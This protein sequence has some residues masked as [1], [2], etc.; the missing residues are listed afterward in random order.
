MQ[1][2]FDEN[3]AI[4]ASLTIRQ[5]VALQPGQELIVSAGLHDAPFVRLIV[6]EAYRAGAKNVAILWNDPEVTLAR[7]REATDEAIGYAPSWLYDGI[8]RAYSENAARLAI[9]S[10]DPGLLTGV[11]PERVATSS[12]ANGIATKAM[13]E[14]IGGFLINWCIVGAASPGWAAKV[15]PG[16]PS[17]EAV[18]KLWDAIF[19]TSRIYEADPI[20]AWVA[21]CETLE[22]RMTWLNDLQLD[23]VHFR[24]PG[25]DLRVGLVEGHV[26][27]GGR[28]H[29]R[30][31]VTCSPNIPTEEVF[32][33]PH[34]ARV[35]GYVSSSKP[36]SVRG[37][38]VDGIRVEFKNGAVVGATASQG[39]ETLQRLIASDEGAKRLGEVALVP[40]SSKVAQAGILFYNTLY[41]ENAACH[42]AL[43]NSLG[44]N[45]TGFETMSPEERLAN[46]A[47]DSI[48]HVDWMIGS[49]A[50]DVDGIRKDGSTVP[51]MRAGEWA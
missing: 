13:S 19:L 1:R 3:L 37:Q 20:D 29:A 36:L 26:W 6:A 43:G 48:I 45:M 7:Y 11:P 2:S 35:D 18:A 17:D 47:N 28:G 46:G 33:M 34:R 15:F 23:A 8:T 27:M 38:V 10:D 24:G 31:G 12:R 42:I 21:H 16:L 50:V 5:G 25:A 4:F 32:T 22:N 40:N 9:A 49:G 30:N 41:D 14:Y 51:V 39:E 44:E